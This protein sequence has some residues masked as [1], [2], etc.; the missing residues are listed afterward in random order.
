[1]SPNRFVS[2]DIDGLAIDSHRDAFGKV[3]ALNMVFGGGRG[4][5]VRRG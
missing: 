5:Y 1:M 4:Y 2:P 3:E